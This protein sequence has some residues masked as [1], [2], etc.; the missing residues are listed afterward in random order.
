[1]L[2]TIFRKIKNRLQ[3]Y[4]Y[5]NRKFK[6]EDEFYTY[7]FTKDPSWSSPTP[8]EDE[9]IRLKEIITEIE[10]IQFGRRIEILEVGCGRGWLSNELTKFGSVCGIEPVSTVVDYAKKIFPKIEFHAGFLD[11]LINKFPNRKFDLVVS[12]EVLEHVNDKPEF[13]KQIKSLINA[14]GIIIITTPRMEIYDSF[15]AK[16]GVEPGQPVEDWLTEDQA[17]KLVF[18][19]GFTLLNHKTFGALASDSKDGNTTQ[20]LVFKSSNTNN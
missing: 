8:N 5:K 4:Y 15:V 12:T 20:L 13:L 19:S 11:S 18:D 17:K 9:T 1:M 14:D 2:H 7:F 6:S 3:Y 10:N 16:Y